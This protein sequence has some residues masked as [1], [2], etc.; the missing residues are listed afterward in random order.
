[1]DAVHR[2]EGTVNQVLG[3][4]VMALLAAP[5]AT[6]STH[7][8]KETRHG[9]TWLFKGMSWCDGGIGTRRAIPIPCLRWQSLVHST[10][11]MPESQGIRTKLC[12]QVLAASY[13]FSRCGFCFRQPSSDG[14][15][16]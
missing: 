2:D 12:Q 3:N 8:W 13:Q 9:L 4:G 11:S 5:L 10:R 15:I 1:M 16:V 7:S 14:K 6:R